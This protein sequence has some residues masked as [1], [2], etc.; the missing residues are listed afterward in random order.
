MRDHLHRLAQVIAATLLE[1]HVLV[2]AA[3]GYIVILGGLYVQ[4]RS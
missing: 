3:R 4:K 2:N 1:D